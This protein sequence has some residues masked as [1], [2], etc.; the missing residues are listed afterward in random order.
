MRVYLVELTGANVAGV[1]TT[2]RFAT[3]GYTTTPTDTPANAFW[4]PR[5]TRVPEIVRS[6]YRENQTSGQGQIGYGVLELVN[7]DGG[8]DPLVD[9]GFD[10]WPCRIY[11]GDTDAAFST[12][13]LVLE[14]TAEQ[15][16]FD[17]TRVLFY[18]RD[19]GQSLDVPA[20]TNRYAGTNV[21][22]AGIE[23]TEDDI[24][25]NVK[26]LC[27]GK[28]VNMAPAFVNTALLIYQV[29]DGA[30][31]SIAV[32]DSRVALVLD[33]DYPDNAA[34]QAA[35]IAAGEYATC[36]AE[37]LFRLG[38]TPTGPIT[39]DVEQSDDTVA[40]IIT[41]LATRAGLTVAGGAALDDALPAK[42]GYLIASDTTL[43]RAI[44]EVCSGVGAYA[45]PDTNGVLQVGLLA[46]PT[47]TPVTVIDDWQI[48]DISRIVPRDTDRGLPVHQ[49]QIAYGRVWQTMTRDQLAGASEADIAT[50]GEQWRIE[51]ASAASVLDQYP[52]SPEIRRDSVLAD[53]ADAQATAARLLG[54]YSVRRDMYNVL[55]ARVPALQLHDVV[56]LI[57]PRYGLASGRLFRV[58][59][60]ESQEQPDRLRLTLWG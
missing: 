16:V 25:G 23:G 52:L 43:L 13:T 29:N 51:T 46:S 59:S 45:A 15:P 20:Q 11:R 5:I 1:A 30:V 47:G 50:V 60:I 44:G 32:Y 31:D 28:V 37:G 38:G 34:L 8:L 33:A 55:V 49:V 18:L 6:L 19:A 54:I 57:H 2:Y 3:G 48:M 17:D 56:R 9:L 58:L 14:G 4:E 41:A 40:A 27:F 39:A 53:T 12:F 10:G 36:L 26:P 35:T 22:P 21:L 42:S 24:K 7:T